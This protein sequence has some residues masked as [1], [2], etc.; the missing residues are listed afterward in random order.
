MRKFLLGSLSV[1]VF[2]PSLVLAEEVVVHVIGLVCGFCAQGIK[3]TFGAEEGVSVAVV[4]LDGKKVV[5][6]VKEGASISDERITE[7]ITDAGYTV[8]AIERR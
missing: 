7:M 8:T 5:L 2:I 4:D 6:S 1:L 3:K